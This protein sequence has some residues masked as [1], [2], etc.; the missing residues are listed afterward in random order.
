MYPT[1]EARARWISSKP[2]RALSEPRSLAGDPLSESAVF[3]ACTKWFGPA[4]RT[5]HGFSLDRKHQVIF[6]SSCFSKEFF[7]DVTDDV[8]FI[9]KF[10]LRNLK[11][12]S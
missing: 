3:C 10:W 9:K 6:S 12:R 2:L 4:V 8:P 1:A 5:A 11:K 7:Y